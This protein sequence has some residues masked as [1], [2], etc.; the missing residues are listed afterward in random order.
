MRYFAMKLHTGKDFV[1]VR[2]ANTLVKDFAV[3]ADGQEIARVENNIHRIV[4]VP[5][6]VTAKELTIQWLA[7]HGAPEVNLFSVDIME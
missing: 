4:T 7:T 6:G 1:P 5:L 3:F 2:V